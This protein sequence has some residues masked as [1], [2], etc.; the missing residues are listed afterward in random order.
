MMERKESGQ[1]GEQ[2]LFA[3]LSSLG[4]DENAEMERL[5]KKF[6]VMEVKVDE[7]YNYLLVSETINPRKNTASK[8]GIA[9]AA[10]L[11]IGAAVLAFGLA[12][13]DNNVMVA[14]LGISVVGIVALF[15]SLMLGSSK[16]T[17]K[18]RPR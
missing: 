4:A 7:I 3:K 5:R 14:S 6:N 13:A 17:Q 1:T 9:A 8:I 16:S 11:A 18:L 12:G 10:I 15:I 2:N